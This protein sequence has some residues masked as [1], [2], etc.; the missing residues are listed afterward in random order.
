M[1]FI[2]KWT[3]KFQ[4]N[5][6]YKYRLISYW[7]LCITEGTK[8]VTG[9]ARASISVAFL[10][11]RGKYSL[12]NSS[13]SAFSIHDV[14]AVRFN[15][16]SRGF[17]SRVF[18]F[19]YFSFVD[20]RVFKE[21]WSWLAVWRGCVNYGGIFFDVNIFFFFWFLNCQCVSDRHVR[22]CVL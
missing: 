14:L 18:K 10:Y 17:V 4:A 7:L 2:S 11:R 20:W 8:G 22:N 15:A 3:K 13:Q 12:L 1:E 6:K 5:G 16:L 9:Y 19:T 21:G